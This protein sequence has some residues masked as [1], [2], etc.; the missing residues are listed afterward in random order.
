MPRILID[1]RAIADRNSGGVGRVARLWIAG[2][3][4]HVARPASL[5]QCDDAT[6]DEFVCFTTGLKPSAEVKKFCDE[7]GLG[8]LHLKI[9]NKIWT[10]G[11]MLGFFSIDR[12]THRRLGKVDRVLLPN[13]GF[14]GE[15]KTPY[16]LL[17]HDVS[18]AIE[19][20]WF[21][22]R[23]RLWHSLLP[24]ARLIKNATHLHCVSQTTGR[25]ARM[26]FGADP[27]KIRTFTFPTALPPDQPAKP[28]WLPESITRFVLLMGGGDPRKNTETALTAI[29]EYNLLH[30]DRGVVP[31]LLGGGRLVHQGGPCGIQPHA[32]VSEAELHYLYMHAA[33]FLYPSWYEGFGLP[34]HEANFY[35]TPVIASTAGAI[36]ETAPLS[37]IFCHPAKPN[38]WTSGLELVLKA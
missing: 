28:C 2:L 11:C 27:E 21:K 10:L 7:L 9:P 34:L 19:P 20:R 23:R 33:A 26:L 35:Q 31:I 14:V 4:S 32:N 16:E 24:V 36:P 29:T 37:T 8:Y 30:P 3:T 13:L 6:C 5:G 12:A 15:L 18:F 25:D 1:A 22:M 17:L 38:E